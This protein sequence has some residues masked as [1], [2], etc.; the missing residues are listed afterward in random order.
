MKN[1]KPLIIALISV[2]AGIQVAIWCTCT[3]LSGTVGLLA[4]PLPTV[5]P[6]VA[7]NGGYV[8]VISTATPKI[9]VIGSTTAATSAPTDTPQ[10]TVTP[11]PTATPQPTATPTPR[12]TATPA[13][14]WKTI[15]TFSGNGNKKTG[16]FDA[17]DSW[18][19]VWSCNPSSSYFGQYNVIIQIYDIYGDYLDLAVNTICQ[20]GNTGDYTQE[21]QG[22]TL[23]LNV[24]SEG[25]WTVKVQVFK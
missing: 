11:S 15:A 2:L 9:V 6:N 21:Y 13:P 18:R 7:N 17:P 1:K 8:H 12:P 5:S 20:K 25:T 4:L 16:T 10:P 23:Y 24:I 3:G 19:L 22:G 14:S